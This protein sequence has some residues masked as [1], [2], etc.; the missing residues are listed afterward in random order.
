MQ[1]Q[2]LGA[3]RAA[4][5]VFACALAAAAHAA[6]PIRVA[7]DR[8][9]PPITYL[10]DGFAKGF[11]VDVIRAL[12]AVL[13]RD[14]QIELST[15]DTAQ[16][17]V[18][19][20]RA[21]ILAGMSI[22]EERRALWDFA[23]PTVTHSFG[24]FVTDKQVAIHGA[25]DLSGK[26]VG[27]TNG[28]LPRTWLK[29]KPGIELVLI[30]NY[31]NGF[32]LLR[33]GEL[34]AVA[35]D[36]WVAGYI[37]SRK[38][39][40]GVALAGTPFATLEGG[41][42]VPKGKTALLAEVNRGLET[43][44]SNG[45]LDDIRRKWEPKQVVFLLKE[46]V[47]S[48]FVYAA[49]AMV[50]L[51][52]VAMTAWILRLKKED[53]ARRKISVELRQF[54]AAVD[55]SAD[56][57]TLIDPRR[58]RY[59]DANDATCK[60]LGYDREEL[61]AMNPSEVFSI[62]GVELGPGY[63]RLMVGDRAPSDVEGTYRRRDGSTFPVESFRRVVPAVDGD[64]IVA[65]ARDITQ[66]KASE[67]KIR[68]LTRVHAVLSAINGAI[69]RIADR[70]AL[71]AEACRVAVQAGEFRMAWIG[72]LDAD[73]SRLK[74]VAWAGEVG[75]YL[76]RVP[77]EIVEANPDGPSL[78]G[79]AVASMQPV[80][81]NDVRSDPRIL[82]KKELEERG[83]SSIAAI[84]LILGER[85]IGALS[86]YAAE[87]GSFDDEE[88]RL[89]LELAGDLSFA[90]DHIE[91][92][93]RVRYLAYYDSLTGVANRTLFLERL[94]PYLGTARSEQQQLALII[95]NIERFKTINDALGRQAGDALLKQM[96]DR[97]L[98]INKDPSRVARVAA[99]H[100]AV[101]VPNVRSLE[102]LIHNGELAQHRL[103]S[104]PYAVG[105]SDI[106]IST[107]AGVALF[108][109]D[110]SDAESLFRNAEAA[111]KK[112]QSGERYVFYASHMTERISEKV[113]LENKLRLALDRDE[114][115]LHYQPKVDTGTGRIAGLEA[116]IRWQNPELGLVPPMQFIPLMEETGLILRVGSAWALK[117]ASLDYRRFAGWASRRASRWNVSPIQPAARL[118]RQREAG[119]RRRQ[120]GDGDRPGDHGKPDQENLEAGIQKLTAVRALGVNIAVDDFGTG[121]SSLAYL[122]RLPLHALKID[123]SF[124]VAMLG[125]SDTM[126][127]VS[128]VISL[129][130]SLKLRVI[131]EGVE[132][133][134]QVTVLRALRCDEMQG[135]LFSKPVPFE[136]AAALLRTGIPPITAPS[137]RD[138]RRPVR[139]SAS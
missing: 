23:T 111:L 108:P 32:E 82:M 70:D 132:S 56:L 29:A 88:M 104:E 66:R 13:D 71:F 129:A 20:G 98:E 53:R 101:V 137:S 61:M 110:A 89:L 58:M 97:L 38:R 72:L 118:R 73:G 139:R 1:C 57:V 78:P 10:E 9:Y 21:D 83:I 24:L 130:H 87:A 49:L 17:Q 77:S 3:I 28:G 47:T 36:T 133:E 68:R 86:L 134:E 105:G 81:S 91:K 33:K 121:Y 54:R 102:T 37:I 34:D 135:F 45:A 22:T 27:V 5:A 44:K 113:A 7:G 35:A 42:A 59:I 136:A 43:L 51:L 131:A 19:E 41:I 93:E 94:S 138:P 6:P 62:A 107:L 60:A 30:A 84:P 119:G 15:W 85:A 112:A 116:L 115:V 8:D 26:R 114:F 67:A 95:V 52:L 65:V 50:V 46:D 80:V 96:A 125:D 39:I 100:F 12:G 25:D 122:A 90:L 99:D 127:V 123:R 48:F 31:E 18:Q 75:D 16:K 92:E 4:A 79:R 128:T 2:G 64:I 76:D 74:P 120:R 11:D 126:A 109:E 14:L 106:R 124:V 63:D 55:A 117:R 40:H 103:D 69:V